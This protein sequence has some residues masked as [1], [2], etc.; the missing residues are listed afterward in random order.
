[1]EAKMKTLS[2]SIVLLLGFAAAAQD[3]V[4]QSFEATGRI[5]FNEI[6]NATGYEVQARSAGGW[7][8]SASFPAAGSGMA[9]ATV[10]MLDQSML[11]RVAATVEDTEDDLYLVIDLSRGSGASIFPVSSLSGVPAGGWTEEHRTTKLVLRRIPAGTFTMGSPT[12]ELGRDSDETQHQV[13]LTQDFYIG[14]F[15]VT[16]EQ[17]NRVMGDWPSYF[18]NV[19]YR[20]SRPVEQVSYNSIRGSSAGV[21]WPGSTAVDAGSFMGRLREKTGLT[22]LDLP[23]E[24]Q[25]EYACRA[26]TTTALNSG[27]NLTSTTSDPNM[28]EVGRYWDNGGSLHM[29]VGDASVGTARVGSYLAN[30]WGLYD[31]HGNAWEWC[32]DW[33]ASSY[34][35]SVVDPVGAA[36][37]S[38]RVKRGGSWSNSAQA[39]RS[40][41]RYSLIPSYGDR[42]LGFRVARTLQ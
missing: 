23:T 7:T 29:H 41:Y 27:K 16:Q 39:C 11:Y 21:G 15:E 6:P 37:G 25:W 30:G 24:S 18:N 19:T 8:N 26:G 5:T 35:G 2:C 3:L 31:M 1:M 36:P 10:S 32:L 17:W 9:T 22:T 28:D 42:S 4:I 14:V 40:A 33:Y 20:A 13:T 12:D 38:V 34:P